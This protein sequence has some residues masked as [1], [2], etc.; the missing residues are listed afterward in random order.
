MIPKFPKFRKL[1]LTDQKDIENISLN[2]PAYSDFDFANMWIWNENNEVEI[3][4]LNSN[5]VVIIKNWVANDLVCSFLGNNKVNE[6]LEEI[7]NYLETNKKDVAGIGLVPEISLVNVDPNKYTTLIDRNNCDYVYDLKSLAEYKGPKYAS[8]R[9]LLNIFSN[10]YK[11]L[12]LQQLDLSKGKVV[13]SIAELNEK[14]ILN[15]QNADLEYFLQK[16]M[17]ALE[18]LINHKF[19][20]IIGLGLFIED[21]LIS[22]SI[23]S[24]AASKYALGLF[25]KYDSTYRGLNEYMMNKSAQYLFDKGYVY[26]NAEEDLGLSGLRFSKNSFRPKEFL[27]KYSVYKR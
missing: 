21:S 8:K 23:L 6:T 3:S 20:N 10:K 5:L 14:W 22:Y 16:E 17:I 15:R 12:S 11:D 1:E 13:K 24:L 2:Y 19:K 26:L 9:N 27:Q 7:F 18:K 25:S 4:T